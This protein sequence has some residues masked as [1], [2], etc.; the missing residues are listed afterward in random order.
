[1]AIAPFRGPMPRGPVRAPDTGAAPARPR[2]LVD[3][4]EFEPYAGPRRVTAAAAEGAR[5]AVTWDDGTRAEFHR[6]WLRDVCACAACRH[7]QTRERTFKL[8]DAPEPGTPEV[9]ASE[10]GALACRWADGHRSLYDPQWLYAR[11][12]GAAAPAAPQR[13]VWTAADRPDG[14][15]AVDHAAVMGGDAGLRRW[16]DALVHD[17]AALVTD[18]P[19]DDL[20]VLRLAG[21][22]GWPRETNFGRHFDVQ[23]KP[24]PNNAAY[25]SI[26]LEPH[27]DLPNWRRA[28]DFQFLYC[29]ENDADGG[30]SLL[31]DGF[32]AA[33]ALAAEDPEAYRTLVTQ[34]VDFRFQDE[35]SDLR[36]RAPTIGLDADGQPA[37]IR[38]NNWIRDNQAMDPDAAERFYRGYH[39]FWQLLRDPRHMIAFR[40]EPGQMLAFDNLRVLHGREEFFPNTGRRHLQG[41]YVDRDLVESRLRVVARDG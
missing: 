15:R 3:M 17:G 25:T 8:V 29:L 31:V 19:C 5:V 14:P 27:V 18:G 7:P 24:N 37:E 33:R 9:A 34:P 26:R 13:R 12:P 39:R 20:E 23:S 10:A 2:P 4:G 6:L 38:F 36:F 40:L 1:M 21:R 32:A 11:R 22:I 16:L 41:C 35:T 28:P 30:D